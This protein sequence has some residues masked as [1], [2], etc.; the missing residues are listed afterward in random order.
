M[1]NL[2]FDRKICQDPLENYFGQ[3]R[4]VGTRKDNTSIHDFGFN[5]NF[6]RNQKIFRPIAGNICGQW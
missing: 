1:L 5:N 2:C 4:A 6:I 3:Q